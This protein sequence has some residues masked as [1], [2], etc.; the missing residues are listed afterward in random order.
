[1]TVM[2]RGQFDRQVRILIPADAGTDEWNEAQD[3]PPVEIVVWAAL[4]S[5][6]GTERFG[7]GEN[8]ALAPMRFFVDWR[9]DLVRPTYAIAYDGQVFDVKSVEEI[10]R[11]KTLQINA[12]ARVTE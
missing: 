5:A 11:R 4:K 12:V 1:M 3:M 7:S 8:L 6:P 10:G 9:P 2:H